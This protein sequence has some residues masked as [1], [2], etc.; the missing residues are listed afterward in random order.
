MVDEY[1]LPD[2][3]DK[4]AREYVELAFGEGVSQNMLVFTVASALRVAFDEGIET[5]AKLAET[6][7][8]GFSADSMSDSFA[9]PLAKEIRAFKNYVGHCPLCSDNGTGDARTK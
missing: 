9:D 3:W 8:I 6:L 5:A 7:R 4:A 1:G 2:K